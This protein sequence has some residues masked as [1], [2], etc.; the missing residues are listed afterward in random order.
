M[1]PIL[2][3]PSV[4]CPILRNVGERFTPRIANQDHANTLA[5]LYDCAQMADMSFE[6]SVLRS[7]A[8]YQWVAAKC[9]ELEELVGKGNVRQKFHSTKNAVK[10]K[11]SRKI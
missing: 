5:V 8:C 4:A 9:Y 11:I 1:Y 3:W 6:Y 7:V 10:Y 2:Y